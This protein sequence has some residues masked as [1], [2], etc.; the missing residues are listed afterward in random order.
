MANS[1]KGIIALWSGSEATIPFGWHLCDGTFDTPDLR[2][3]FIVGAGP[4]YPAAS[5]GG[6]ASH[7]H[8]A[9]Q[10]SHNHA[11]RSDTGLILGPGTLRAASTY[12]NTPPITVD[13]TD[14]L[15]PYYALCYIMHI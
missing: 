3:K 2:D 15:P 9:T 10:T 8:T 14:S 7:T 11:L 12:S 6:S 1:M 13:P 4:I 5:S